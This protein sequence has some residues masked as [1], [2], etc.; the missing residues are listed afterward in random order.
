MAVLPSCTVKVT[1]RVSAAPI[2]TGFESALEGRSLIDNQGQSKLSKQCSK[3]SQGQTYCSLRPP[4]TPAPLATTF[5]EPSV[6][7]QEAA[8]EVDVRADTSRNACDSKPCNLIV[9]CCPV[10]ELLDS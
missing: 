3:S 8:T 6:K 7:V 2:V 10:V 9:M 5:T 4:P 1:L